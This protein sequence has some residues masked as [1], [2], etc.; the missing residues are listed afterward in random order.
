MDKENQVKSSKRIK[1]RASYSEYSNFA[2]KLKHSLNKYG[3][4]KN[5][6]VFKINNSNEVLSILDNIEIDRFAKRIVLTP[7][8]IIRTKGKPVLIDVNEVKLTQTNVSKIISKYCQDYKNYF[9]KFSKRNIHT[10]LDPIPY[11]V[12]VK[13]LGLISIGSSVKAIN[14]IEDIALQTLRVFHQ[15]IKNK[16]DFIS[17]SESDLFEMEYWSLEQAKLGSK[18]PQKLASKVIVIT[19]GGGTIGKACAK[20]MLDE[21]GNVLL[22]D[23]T[24]EIIDEALHELNDGRVKGI[25]LDITN[26]NAPKK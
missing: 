10:M 25:S 21:G 9:R 18:K 15:H 12:W 14:I 11:M 5:G 2:I 19:G 4:N 7:D 6:Y 3:S 22:V 13:G 26:K 16:E 8:H 24:Q 17:L 23:R 1:K 20:K